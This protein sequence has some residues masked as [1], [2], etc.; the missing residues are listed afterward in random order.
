[1]LSRELNTLALALAATVLVLATFLFRGRPL[2]FAVSAALLSFV[3]GMGAGKLETWRAGTPMLGS[4]V[5]T[6]ITGRLVRLEEQAN[7]RFRL[8]IDVVGTERPHL[9]HPPDRVRL[10]ARKVPSS[11]R[12]G[13]GIKG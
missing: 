7:G 13:D 1:S 6:H 5:T 9:R 2:A 4:E 10:T 11:L 3:L 8:V 12:P